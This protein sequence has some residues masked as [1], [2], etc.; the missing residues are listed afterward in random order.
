[1]NALKRIA[2]LG[3]VVLSGVGVGC[4]PRADH[5]IETVSR[6][7]SDAGRPSDADRASDSSAPLVETGVLPSR[8][9]ASTSDASV[10]NPSPVALAM[11]LPASTCDETSLVVPEA[12]RHSDVTLW[13]ICYATP[14]SET[15]SDVLATISPRTVTLTLRHSMELEADDI[16]WS[17]LPEGPA[18]VRVSFLV[19]VPHAP[20]GYPLFN[21]RNEYLDP[22]TDDSATLYAVQPD[23]RRRVLLTY[24]GV[25]LARVSPDG[26]RTE[27]PFHPLANGC[28][29]E[30]SP[31]FG[32]ENGGC[33][34][35]MDE[36]CP[37][38]YQICGAYRYHCE[39]EP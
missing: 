10:A 33:F 28:V 3:Y 37:P 2:V 1:M 32:L 27:W 7:A 21:L 31:E 14:T 15:W 8:D 20:D 25:S 22:T 5:P 29:E 12:F 11:E 13:H 17:S 18:G 39:Y 6:R 9:D 19:A 30:L 23:E 4:M 26:L 34:V 36:A 16:V 24:G 38:E 35:P